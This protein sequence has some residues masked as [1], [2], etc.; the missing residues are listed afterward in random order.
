MG[1]V[2]RAP[3]SG[4][5]EARWRDPAG[6]SRTRTFD[7]KADARAYL[8]SV[9]TDVH[10]GQYVDP[11]GGRVLFG[12]WAERWWS[13]TV[14]LRPSTRARDDSLYRNHIEPTFGAFPLAGIDHLGVCEWIAEL[15]ACG[16]A[17]TTVH[18]CSQILAKVMRAAVDA[19]LIAS[20]PC[21]RQPLPKIERD[22]MRFL[23]PGEVARL[24]D[25]I[26]PG[27]RSLVLVGAYGGLRS[28][29]M[30]GLRRERVDTLRAR[31]DVAE[32]L[33]E[34][35]GHHHVGPPKTRAG[36]RSVPL[37]RF[38]ADELAAHLEGVDGLV[39]PA[40]QGGQVRASLFRRRVWHPAVEATGL[41][42]LR[43]H[44]LRHTAVA[45]WIAAGASPKEIAARAGH[46]SVATVLDRYGH[47]LPGG[48]EKVT[49][50]LDAMARQAARSSMEA[51]VMPI[52]R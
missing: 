15:S 34:V 36:R 40:P 18:K 4:R 19:G 16:L 52:H 38:V 49:D 2:R 41:E 29:E 12:E 44:D 43:L 42:P 39:F 20:S 21:E 35:N 13:T 8:S 33:V 5:W 26:G 14:N 7:T 24:A 17:P 50:A 10:R 45:F 28:G 51:Q 11:A 27:Y 22:E 9:E 30:F 6:R 23:T 37:P 31:I 48:E 25:A 32:V 1:S 47:L 46:T 3:R